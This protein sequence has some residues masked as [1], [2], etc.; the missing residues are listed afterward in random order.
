MKERRRK[1]RTMKRKK[2]KKK[3]KTMPL[4]SI[5]KLPKSQRSVYFEYVII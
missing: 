5:S 3:R 4:H 1:R 2:K